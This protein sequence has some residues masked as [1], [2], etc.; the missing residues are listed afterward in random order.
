M[1]RY[2]IDTEK[3]TVKEIE[4]GSALGGLIILGIIIAILGGDGSSGVDYW[5]GDKNCPIFVE[6]DDGSLV[7]FKKS[8][9]RQVDGN[10]PNGDEVFVCTGYEVTYDDFF[11]E[12]DGYIVIH[13]D[14]NDYYGVIY[15]KTANFPDGYQIDIE[16]DYQRKVLKAI[17]KAS[18]D[19]PKL[20]LND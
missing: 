13:N 12:Y 16:N 4:E 3:G 19:N 9:A 15:P 10:F 5:K 2:E 17:M 7:A 1:A 20:K 6:R 8:T 11:Q 14:K 18:S